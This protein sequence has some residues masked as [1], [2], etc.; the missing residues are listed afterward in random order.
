MVMK[1]GTAG[2]DA[3]T[4]HYGDSGEGVTVNLLF[5]VASGGTAIGDTSAGVENVTGPGSDD[6]ILGDGLAN[7]LRGAGGADRLFAWLAT[8]S[9]PV[10]PGP[11]SRSAPPAPT[12]PIIPGPSRG[13][14][15]T[16]D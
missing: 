5:N 8:T 7:V 11:I 14:R 10:A 4:A 2:A 12:P 1:T 9:S 6:H 16:V 15:S 3:Y 13:W